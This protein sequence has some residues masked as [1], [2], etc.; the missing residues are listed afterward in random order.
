MGTRLRLRADFDVSTY[1]KNIQVILVAMKKYGI[2]LADIGSDMYITGAP[3][4][5]WDNDEL[6]KLGTVKAG[7]FIVTQMGT[8]VTQ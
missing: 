2:I 4:E 3:D 1:P 6:Q 7:D 5:R 8:V